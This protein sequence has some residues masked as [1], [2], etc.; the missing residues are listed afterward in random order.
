MFGG[1]QVVVCGY[2]EVRY[3]F[4][5][6]RCLKYILLKYTRLFHLYGHKSTL[7][8]HFRWEKSNFKGSLV[9]V[10]SFFFPLHFCYFLSWFSD[11][12]STRV[13]D[14]LLACVLIINR[15]CGCSYA[16]ACAKQGLG[17][18]LWTAFTYLCFLFFPKHE[19]IQWNSFWGRERRVHFTGSFEKLFSSWLALW[20]IFSPLFRWGRGAALP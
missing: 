19:S 7:M 2:G 14:V 4:S 13:Y 12:S 5:V 8:Y 11:C 3:N 6:I 16:H 9:K 20:C 1:K 10:Q 18:C 15:E 17:V